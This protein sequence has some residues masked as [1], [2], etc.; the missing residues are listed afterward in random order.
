MHNLLLLTLIAQIVDFYWRTF[1]ISLLA[2]SFTFKFFITLIVYKSILLAIIQK[3]INISSFALSFNFIASAIE[4]VI[5]AERKFLLFI[6]DA[7][8]I[9]NNTLR[10]INIRRATIQLNYFFFALRVLIIEVILFEQ[11][12][13]IFNFLALSCL[14]RSGVHIVE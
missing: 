1:F 8:F 14:G 13:L 2:F 7:K 6:V 3:V 10:N 12:F 11:L 9:S 4:V 5:S